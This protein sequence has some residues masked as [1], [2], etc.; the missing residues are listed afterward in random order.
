[1]AEIEFWRD[2]A[3]SVS[4]LHEQLQ[5]PAV[6][7]VLQALQQT[8]EPPALLHFR[9][10][11]QEL[12]KMQVEAKDNVRALRD[13]RTPNRLR[14]RRAPQARDG[15]REQAFRRSGETSVFP[16]TAS[17]HCSTNI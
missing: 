17:R 14:E 4:T 15:G 3:S 13:P 5:L 12:Q 9:E 1:M 2:R 10:Q 7:R 11:F 8:S 16:Q 6:Q